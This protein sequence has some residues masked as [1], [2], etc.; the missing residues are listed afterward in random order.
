MSDST[1]NTEAELVAFRQ[2]WREEVSSRNQQKPARQQEQ[3]QKHTQPPTAGPATARRKEVDYSEEIEPRAYHDLPDKDEQLKLGAGGD[4]RIRD[5]R[6]EPSSALEHYE[7]AVEKETQGQLGDSVRHYRRAFK[8]DDGVHEAYKRKHFPP[9]SFVKPAPASVKPSN[10]S[11]TVPGTAHPSLHGSGAALPPTLKQLVDEFAGMRIEAPPPPTDASPQERSLLGELPEEILSHILMEVAINDVATFARLAQVCK[12]LAHL[13]LTEEAIWRRVAV[14]SEFGFKAMLYD[15]ACEIDGDPLDAGDSIARYL[16]DT[17]DSW[18]SEDDLPLLPAPRETSFS[19]LSNHLLHSTY[20]SSYRQMFRSRPRIRFNGCYI[21]TV[22]YTRPGGN[23]TN[24][25]TWGAPVHVVTYFRYLRFFP[26]GTAISLLT[27]TEPADVVHH[28]TKANL[29]N[30][31][32]STAL[33]SSVMRDALRGRWRLT[34]PL[35]AHSK[36]LEEAEVEG[37]LI[38]ET[39][40]VVPKYTYQMHLALSRAGKSTRN[41]KLAWKWYGCYNRLTDDWGE[42]GLKN[43]QAFYYSRVKSYGRAS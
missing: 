26:D 11:A 39:E 13:V 38:V 6:G 36:A 15:F 21:S 7:R 40:G 22:N 8:L 12:R 35:S 3:R 28:L 17:S 41:N 10:A 5:G 2:R 1:P 9:S 25:L 43:D 33:P 34:G 30:H 31:H 19:A 27:T 20:A 4:E 32:T 14:G 16:D 29:H 42:F 37:D 18:P 24:T 23:N